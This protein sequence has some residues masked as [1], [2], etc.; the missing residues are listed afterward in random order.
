MVSSCLN[1]QT[2]PMALLA[3]YGTMRLVV[4]QLAAANQSRI[5]PSTP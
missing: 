5:L 4:L 3:G 2:G 1:G